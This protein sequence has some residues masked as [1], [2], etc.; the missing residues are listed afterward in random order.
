MHLCEI[1]LYIFACF[2]I[3]QSS[4]FDVC[5]HKHTRQNISPCN[6]RWQKAIAFDIAIEEKIID[7]KFLPLVI[8]L[9]FTMNLSLFC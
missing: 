2:V 3:C 9:Q 7:R 1:Y 4:P 5:D 6:Y 8:Y